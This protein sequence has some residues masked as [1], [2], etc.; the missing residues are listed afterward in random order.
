[1]S[2][3]GNAVP[4]P[5]DRFPGECI[6]AGAVDGSG[7]RLFGYAIGTDLA[8]HYSFVEVLLLA[9]TGELP[10]APETGRACAI[11]LLNLSSVTIADA[12]VHAARV[13]RHVASLSKN[14]AGVVATAAVGLAEQGRFELDELAPLLEWLETDRSA[15]VPASARAADDIERQ[16]VTRFLASL[17]A[18]H[19]LEDL[20]TTELGLR[21]AALTVLVR[22][23]LKRREQLLAALVAVRLPIAVAEAY[24][25]QD[26]RLW[27]YPLNLP[28]WIYV[29]EGQ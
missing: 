18:G 20:V 4:S 13:N 25:V 10:E 24:S 3:D 22:C 27:K 29:P 23:G 11:A 12:S 26:P 21:A 14:H 7:A 28:E 17:P 16:R 6:E 15:P 5:F 9:L 8:V 1:M 2:S 19:R